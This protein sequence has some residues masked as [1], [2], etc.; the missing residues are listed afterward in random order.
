MFSFF[1]HTLLW[2]FAPWCLMFYF[3]LYKIIRQII[4]KQKPAEYYTLSGGLLLLLLFSLSKFQL[5]FYTN[6]L[7][8]LFAVITAPWCYAQLNK[9]ESKIRLVSQWLYIILFPI[10]VLLINYFSGSPGIIY[11]AADCLAL[12]LLAFFITTKITNDHKKVFLLN[13][14]VV[15]FVNF[16]LN[17][18]F[19]KQIVAYKGQITAANYINQPQFSS[20]QV[21][22]L[23]TENN[24]FQFYCNRPVDFIPLEQFSNFKPAGNTAYYANQETMDFLLK[25]KANFKLLKSFIDYPQENILPAFINIKTRSKTLGRVYLITK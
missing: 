24:I 6:T 13:C 25:S 4:N 9:V 17:T 15:L 20:Y 19:Y 7:F 12:A 21:Y 18:V 8:P 22:S 23:R 10:A 14:A 5:P 2:A 1:V 11:F 16:Y 3:A